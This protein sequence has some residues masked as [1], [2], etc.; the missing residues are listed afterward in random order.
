MTQQ[1]HTRLSEA[2]S[3]ITDRLA[4]PICTPGTNEYQ[5]G[6]SLSRGAAGIALLHTERALIGHGDWNIVHAWL[7]SAVS[8]PINGSSDAGLFYG[9]P[10]LAFSVYAAAEDQRYR[11]ARSRLHTSVEAVTHRRLEQAQERINRGDR[12]ALREYDALYGLAG[13]GAYL[14]HR[15]PE[16]ALT[17]GVLSYLVRLSRP[18]RHDTEELPGWWTHL[19][20]NGRTSSAFPGGHGN[21][22]MA[23]GIS[24]PLSVLALAMRRGIVVKGQID[25]IEQICS[26]LDTWQQESAAGPW[27]PPTVSRQEF[28]T[29]RVHQEEPHRPSWCYGTPGIARA[30]QLA[31]LAIKDSERQRTAE[32]ALLGCLSDT[33]QLTR[34]SDA[35]LCHGAA[36]FVHT[37]WRAAADAQDA[38]L[39]TRLPPVAHRL[40]TR[41]WK[42]EEHG[43]LD[44]AAGVALAL[45][46][47]VRGES[48]ASSW[49]S[50]LLIN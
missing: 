28:L 22:G 14:L 32:K 26:W 3:F 7:T 6:Q 50:C 25:A 10:A 20:P 44:G 19:A 34:I 16:G 5:L 43:L 8:G 1:N 45:L 33:S 35:G 23:H 30:Q 36:G 17:R 12:P 2:I 11:G 9:A 41:A 48:P 42:T 24:G 39:A 46:T 37:M 31:G 49:D 47:A 29:H 4:R 15:A 27:W 18:V 13:L 21:S 40:L 38:R